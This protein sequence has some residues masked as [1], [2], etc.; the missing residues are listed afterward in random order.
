MLASEL[1]SYENLRYDA[2]LEMKDTTGRI[3]VFS[4]TQRIRVRAAPLPFFLDRLWG[5]GVLTDSYSVV[6]GRVYDAVRLRNGVGVFLTFP[7]RLRPGDVFE[8]TT[9]RRMVGVFTDDHSYW[10]LVMSAPT[11]ILTLTVS[12]PPGLVIR[13]P[14]VSASRINAISAIERPHS[15]DLRVRDVQ[16]HVRHRIEWDW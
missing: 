9:S 7:K 12:A 11:R 10:D 14:T 15:V 6:G 8:F 3:A 2:R 13:K 16:L 1:H 4:R 5:E